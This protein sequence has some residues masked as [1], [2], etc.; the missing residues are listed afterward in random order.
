MPAPSSTPSRTR[1]LDI[2][3]AAGFASSPGTG[4]TSTVDGHRVAVGS[5]AR[6]VPGDRGIA[7][8]GR[9]EDVGCTAVLVEVDGVAAGVLGITDRLR[10]DAAATVT[11]LTGSVPIPVTGDN[12]RTVARVAGETGISDVRAGLLP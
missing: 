3:S 7:L 2:S 11:A 12:P 8:V 5:P 1:G 10:P 9:L 6:L 4:V